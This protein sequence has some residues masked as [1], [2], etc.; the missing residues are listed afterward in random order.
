MTY[1]KV[2]LHIGEPWVEA[3]EVGHLV[4]HDRGLLLIY[5]IVFFSLPEEGSATAEAFFPLITDTHHY[6]LYFQLLEKATG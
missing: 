2:S 3:N 5:V 4:I 1:C 6:L